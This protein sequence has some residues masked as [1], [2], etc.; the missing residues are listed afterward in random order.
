LDNSLGTQRFTIPCAFQK[1]VPLTA[2]DEGEIARQF[3][4]KELV[5][6]GEEVPYSRKL[7]KSM[8]SLGDYLPGGVLLRG[9][10]P[11]DKSEVEFAGRA[12]WGRE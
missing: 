12:R 6:R 7:L 4:R 5:R 1:F 9:G 2:V 8:S 11:N 3:Q 10:D